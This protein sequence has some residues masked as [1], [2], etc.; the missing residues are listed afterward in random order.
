[1]IAEHFI[2][3]VMGCRT[4][5]LTSGSGQPLIMVSGWLGTADNFVPLMERLSDNFF[6]IA[7]DLPGLGKTTPFKDRKHT[8]ENYSDFVETLFKKMKISKPVV[9]GI[10]LGASILLDF[11]ERTKNKPSKTILQSPVY[12]P[13]DIDTKA[14][15]SLWIMNNFRFVTATL[16]QLCSTQFFKR[17]VMLCG[18]TNVKSI[19][20]ETLSKYGTMGLPNY[21][22]NAM[23]EVVNDVVSLDIAKELPKVDCPILLFC[24]T[25]EN[26]FPPSYEGDLASRLPNCRYQVIEKGTHYLFLQKPDEMAKWIVDFVREKN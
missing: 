13:I 14:K 9:L 2:D 4:R 1:M 15:L 7:I 11:D 23:L 10:S 8:V 19:S 12:R 6:C 20:F 17:V 18:D 21:N 22:V 5:Y 24:G 26:L 25:D 16:L 3:D